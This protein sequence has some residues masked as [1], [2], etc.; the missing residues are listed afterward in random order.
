MRW[1][2]EGRLAVKRGAG[3]SESH[4]GVARDALCGGKKGKEHFQGYV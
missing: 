2:G 3:M 1:C 4:A